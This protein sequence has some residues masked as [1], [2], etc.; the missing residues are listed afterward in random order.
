MNLYDIDHRLL[1]LY[2]KIEEEEGEIDDVTALELDELEMAFEKKVQNIALYH[3]TLLAEAKAIK[4]E[5][6][7]L[8]DRQ[9]QKERRAENLKQYLSNVLE[10]KKIEGSNFA[11]NWRKS[12]VIPESITEANA[13][14]EFIKTKIEKSV[15]KQGLKKAI[16]EGLVTY[17]NLEQ[18]NN[19]QIK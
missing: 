13:P 3:K 5:R 8:Y 14:A 9:K 4:E 12:E 18:K 1:L 16:K 17:I 7:I 15:D 11:I 2:S 6:E 10:G 19:I